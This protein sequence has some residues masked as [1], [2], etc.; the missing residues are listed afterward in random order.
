MFFQTLSF[1]GL[2]HKTYF[3]GKYELF[4]NNHILKK[5]LFQDHYKNISELCDL[6]R[7]KAVTNEFVNEILVDSTK[8]RRFCNQVAIIKKALVRREGTGTIEENLLKYQ[9]PS[10]LSDVIKLIPVTFPVVQ[11]WKNSKMSKNK[12]C[13][14][15]P[16]QMGGSAAILTE[17]LIQY[18][19]A[20]EMMVNYIGDFKVEPTLNNF[21]KQT[22][23]LRKVLIDHCFQKISKW[24]ECDNPTTCNRWDLHPPCLFMDVTFRGGK[25]RQLSMMLPEINFLGTII[26]DAF[27]KALKYTVSTDQFT[28]AKYY[29]DT[30]SKNYSKGDWMH[31]GDMESCTNRFD[32]RTSRQIMTELFYYITKSKNSK[33]RKIIYTVFSF[34][35]IYMQDDHLKFLRD[36]ELN[37]KKRDLIMNYLEE[38]KYVKQYNGQHMGASL[39]FFMMGIMHALN[40]KLVYYRPYL[41]IG[42]EVWYDYIHKKRIPDSFRCYGNRKRDEEKPTEDGFFTTFGDDSLHITPHYE[43]IQR[44]SDIVEVWNMRWSKKGNFISQEGCVFTERVFVRNGSKL[45]PLLHAKAKLLFRD[46]GDT[47]PYFISSLRSLD[48]IFD[49]YDFKYIQRSGMTVQLRKIMDLTREIIKREV[50][51]L[52][53]WV[54]RNLPQKYGGVGLQGPLM[55]SDRKWLY[56]LSI[57]AKDRTNYELVKLLKPIKSLE[58]KFAEIKRRTPKFLEVHKGNIPMERS[59]VKKI[60]YN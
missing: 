28:R 17:E 37:P 54:P 50:R 9:E 15:N 40:E 39:S 27:K 48:S 26:K 25:V 23:V 16:S 45:V 7:K 55:R 57:F 21:D 52:P 22:K 31:S 1:L 4:Y 12:G 19:E 53:K 58:P 41:K 38:M 13:L 46:P 3:S 56:M 8:N 29:Y 42:T 47:K 18:N 30:I 43:D 6:F 32:P 59:S 10:D 5:I 35:R 20:K 44:M 34:F 49:E 11:D 51:K 2:K 14:L 36:S 33:Y 24:H 60:I